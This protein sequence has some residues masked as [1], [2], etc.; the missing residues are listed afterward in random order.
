[1]EFLLRVQIL[2]FHCECQ[3]PIRG[4]TTLE[5]TC[6]SQPALWVMELWIPAPFPSTLSHFLI[7]REVLFQNLAQ[8]LSSSWIPSSIC[9]LDYDQS[10]F[11]LYPSLFKVV[12]QGGLM[13][14][15]YWAQNLEVISLIWGRH[16]SSVTTGRFILL[17]WMHLHRLLCHTS[18][19]SG[20]MSS[21]GAGDRQ[22]EEKIRKR[23]RKRMVLCGATN[24][25]LVPS[26][27]VSDL[28]FFFLW[29][30]N[31]FPQLQCWT[32]VQKTKSSRVWEAE[33]G[34]TS[35]PAKIT[36]ELWR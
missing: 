7:S 14:G 30:L 35:N 29:C 26:L 11:G 25:V 8:T 12:N 32:L 15:Q 24:F 9:F 2:F 21:W 19:P 20:L 31:L 17:S 18:E 22:Q 10:L 23:E 16:Q 28:V 13:L 5:W 3:P 34:K 36:A 27:T 4:L 33:R 1:M 6:I